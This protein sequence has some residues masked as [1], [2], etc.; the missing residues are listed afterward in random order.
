MF[1]DEETGDTEEHFEKAKWRLKAV[2]ARLADEKK[3]EK[4][5]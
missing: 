4:R 1:R 3:R 2:K 5:S